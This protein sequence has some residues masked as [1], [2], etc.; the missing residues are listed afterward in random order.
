M[1]SP[2]TD[3]LERMVFESLMSSERTRAVDRQIGASL[4]GV[5]GNM[6]SAGG[7][8]TSDINEILKEMRKGV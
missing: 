1:S 3:T 4:M 7:E 8:G 2:P 6:L 5:Y